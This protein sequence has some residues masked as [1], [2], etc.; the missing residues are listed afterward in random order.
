[1]VKK[2][3]FNVLC[4]FSCCQN[5]QIHKIYPNLALLLKTEK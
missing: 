1:M 5:F 4:N 3:I 2:E